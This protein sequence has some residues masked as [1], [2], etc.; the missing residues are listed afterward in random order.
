MNLSRPR[1]SAYMKNGATQ[2]L[3]NLPN[4]RKSNSPASLFTPTSNRF[5]LH[6][7]HSSPGPGTIME[8]L[9]LKN[10]IKVRLKACQNLKSRRKA[11]SS[12]RYIFHKFNENQ[13]T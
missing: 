1:S 5:A 7:L 13:S 8:R 4:L 10:F 12:A 3:G 6:L 11:S 9:L 2:W